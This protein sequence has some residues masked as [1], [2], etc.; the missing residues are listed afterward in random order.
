MSKSW[1]LFIYWCVNIVH[2]VCEHVGGAVCSRVYMKGRGK[3]QLSCSIIFLP[4]CLTPLR[5]G[6]PLNL[7]L[8]QQPANPGNPPVSIPT[9]LGLHGYSA[10]PSFL[11]YICWG[12]LFF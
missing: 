6:L 12:F 8:G 7:E 5:Q 4:F 1:I 9:G 11:D 10:V 2:G 3:R